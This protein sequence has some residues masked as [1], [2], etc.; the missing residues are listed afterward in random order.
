MVP[1]DRR[2]FIRNLCTSG[3]FLVSGCLKGTPQ[4]DSDHTVET[5]VIRATDPVQTKGDPISV[6]QTTTIVNALTT[7]VSNRSNCTV[8]EIPIDDYKAGFL[9]TTVTTVKSAEK[10]NVAFPSPSYRQLERIIPRSVAVLPT[11]ET[12]SSS[13]SKPI[14]IRAV[15]QQGYSEGDTPEIVENC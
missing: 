8:D 7:A 2:T 4:S 5:R 10:T 14:Y 12:V 15:L 11:D 6:S 3:I 9:V 1:G 13:D